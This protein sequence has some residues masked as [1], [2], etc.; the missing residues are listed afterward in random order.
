MRYTKQFDILLVPLRHLIELILKMYADVLSIFFVE[1]VQVC[2]LA[3]IRDIKEFLY[4]MQLF[5]ILVVTL[6]GD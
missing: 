6:K 1:I 2:K 4:S 5:L 3:I